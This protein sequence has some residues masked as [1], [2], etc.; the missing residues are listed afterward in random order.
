[1]SM[2]ALTKTHPQALRDLR[3]S[4]Y[5]SVTTLAMLAQVDWSTIWRIE[6]GKGKYIPHE[7]TRRAIAGA[8]GVQPSDIAEFTATPGDSH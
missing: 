6:T 8:L 4:R 2:E 5:W 7:G 1:V 3:K